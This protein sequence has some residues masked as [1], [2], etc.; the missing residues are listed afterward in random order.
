MIPSPQNFTLFSSLTTATTSTSIHYPELPNQ[1]TGLHNWR[2]TPLNH[3]RFWGP[4]G[5]DIVPQSSNSI[6]ESA[7]LDSISS[8]S[9]LAEM[10]AAVLSTSDPLTKSKLTHLGYCRWRQEG[11]PVGNFEP[12]V[13]PAR[14]SKPELVC[15]FS[16][17]IF[18]PS[19][20]VNG[21]QFYGICSFYRRNT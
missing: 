13:R 3:N 15:L 16:F 6:Q 20:F 5:P 14:P 2:H 4:N 7:L 9:S 8:A 18:L 17:F 10:G 19:F 11:L 21:V 12:P 1:W